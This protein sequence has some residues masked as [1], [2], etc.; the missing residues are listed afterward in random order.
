VPSSVLLGPELVFDVRLGLLTPTEEKPDSAL[1]RLE[2]DPEG[3]KWAALPL[4]FDEIQDA[5]GVRGL[6]GEAK[7]DAPVY[8]SGFLSV[9][10]ELFRM[11]DV[12]LTVADRRKI[13]GD[14]C[15]LRWG[16]VEE[17]GV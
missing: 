15:I 14:G 13:A 6:P 16:R 12:P 7:G 8:L 1:L 10:E 9:G 3:E 11:G 5:F 17:I 4:S 2:G